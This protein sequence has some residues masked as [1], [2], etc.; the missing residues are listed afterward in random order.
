MQWRLFKLLSKIFL[1]KILDITL[2]L[3]A[4][5]ALFDASRAL[6]A[7]HEVCSGQ[8]SEHK[9]CDLGGAFI[10]LSRERESGLEVYKARQNRRR[11]DD[12]YAKLNN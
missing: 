6:P 3:V 2:Q 12:R 8:E 1:M 10:P 11:Q 5:Y 7:G 9:N 4:L